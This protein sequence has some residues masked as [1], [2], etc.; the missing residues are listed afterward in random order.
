MFTDRG[1]MRWVRG[2]E[3]R[4]RNRATWPGNVAARQPRTPRRDRPRCGATTRKGTPC[5]APVAWDDRLDRPVNGRCRYHGGASTGPRT[6]AGRE[7]IRESN[8]RRAV[9]R[10]LAELVPELEAERR[11]RWADAVLALVYGYPRRKGKNGLRQAGEAAGVSRQ[12][13]SRWR[14]HPGFQEAQRRAGVRWWTWW[15]RDLRERMARRAAERYGMPLS[16][17]LAYL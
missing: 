8:R 2:W 14:Q 13:V 4:Q 5:A 12:T 17:L 15:N 9:L 6:D 11:E 10:D 1:M 16:E 7:A 3:Q